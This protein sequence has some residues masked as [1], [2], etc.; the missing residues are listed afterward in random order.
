MTQA[1]LGYPIETTPNTKFIKQQPRAN[2][3]IVD[4]LKHKYPNWKK[5]IETGIIPREMMEI[6]ERLVAADCRKY[7]TYVT[8]LRYYDPSEIPINRLSIHQIPLLLLLHNK[9]KRGIS[10]NQ[11]SLLVHKLEVYLNGFT[12]SMSRSEGSPSFHRLPHFYHSDPRSYPD[13]TFLQF[14]SGYLDVF[15]NWFYFRAS[16]YSIPESINFRKFINT[17]LERTLVNNIPVSTKQLSYNKL[18]E[19][20]QNMFIKFMGQTVSDSQK[21]INNQLGEVVCYRLEDESLKIGLILFVEMLNSLNHNFYYTS[22]SAKDLQVDVSAL[23]N[24]TVLTILKLLK[25]LRNVS[26]GVMYINYFQKDEIAL[27]GRSYHTLMMI[28]KEDRKFINI[29]G[30]D[31]DSAL[32]TIVYYMLPSIQDKLT[33][34]KHYIDNKSSVRIEVDALLEP[35]ESIHDDSKVM[36]T[37][38]YQG[39]LPNKTT[40]ALLPELFKETELIRDAVWSMRKDKT[41]VMKFAVRRMKDEFGSEYKKYLRYLNHD[42]YTTSSSD[43]HDMKTRLLFFW[44]TYYEGEIRRLMATPLSNP[45]DFHDAIYTQDE[46][47]FIDYDIDA[48]ESDIY[49]E[50]GIKMKLKKEY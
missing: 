22:N 30:I 32:Q 27:F 26:G 36:I 29:Y 15:I 41:L 19:R 44:W 50:F 18:P 10:L 48:M 5:T 12:N 6:N 2:S 4:T 17:M 38:C 21:S 7:E 1:E 37:A 14:D 31:M 47:E 35:H 45:V 11:S 3:L 16:T 39:R 42:K 49:K 24:M 28:P 43:L 25:R 46:E 20:L 33:W 40:G 23:K 34:T 8:N 13:K 9:R